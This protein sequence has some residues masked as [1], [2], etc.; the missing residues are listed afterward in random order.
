M[1]KSS[2]LCQTIQEHSS[3]SILI[4]IQTIRRPHLLFHISLLRAQNLCS[5]HIN[6]SQKL[7][8]LQKPLGYRNH[9]VS[10][11]EHAKYRIKIIMDMST[12]LSSIFLLS[13]FQIQRITSSVIYWLM[14]TFVPPCHGF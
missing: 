8:C 4:M 11:A 9:L 6:N 3:H 1:R 12:I 7:N 5:Q 14:E 2:S 10:F 13:I